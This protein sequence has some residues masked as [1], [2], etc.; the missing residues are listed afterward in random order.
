MLSTVGLMYLYLSIGVFLC[1]VVLRVLL[2]RF[3]GGCAGAIPVC[4]ASRI[5]LRGH[6]R[7][8]SPLFPRWV[9]AACATAAAAC[10]TAAAAGVGT[11]AFCQ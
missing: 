4:E 5:A 8:R 3:V 9:A 10:V 1:V 7:R 2:I 11:D 6:H